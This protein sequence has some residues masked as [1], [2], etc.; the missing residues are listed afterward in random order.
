M[1]L[2]LCFILPLSLSSR[3][4]L[5]NLL[6]KVSK[7][8]HGLCVAAAHHTSMA[9]LNDAVVC[10]S[11]L[12]H[13]EMNVIN[14]FKQAGV[15]HLLIVS[16]AHLFLIEW[17]IQKI[18]GKKTNSWWI[19]TILIVYSTVALFNPPIVRALLS[20][21]LR[22][23][24][25]A[26]S[27]KW[28]RVQIV[29]LSAFATLGFCADE[30]AISSLLISWAAALSIASMPVRHLSLKESMKSL[31]SLATNLWHRLSLQL[32]LY[33]ALLIPLLPYSAPHP[34]TILIQLAIYPILI[35]V[36]F[37]FSLLTVLFS[38]LDA[39]NKFL[40]ESILLFLDTVSRNLPPS[41]E[42]TPV[43][44]TVLLSYVA[45]LTFFFWS[46]ERRQFA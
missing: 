22:Q 34:L 28:T 38:P 30:R 41:L 3:F 17:W 33:I 2:L 14:E 4:W 15:I 45:A 27:L 24:N 32:K 9:A 18:F 35:V 23:L 7:P 40:W 42:S 36:I 11:R 44:F 13:S 26:Q 46:A 5:P 39:L 10:G 37:P 21:C 16:G 31:S 12:T 43:S 29:T 25:R 20:W 6:M 1:L 8:F 19:C